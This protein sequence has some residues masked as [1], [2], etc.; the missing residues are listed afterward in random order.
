MNAVHDPR[1]TPRSRG[2]SWVTYYMVET[3]ATRRT[4]PKRSGVVS[5]HDKLT[6]F[7]HYSKGLGGMFSRDITR[8][9]RLGVDRTRIVLL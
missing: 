1:S 8:I 3:L 5:V 9:G 7:L 2:G 4:L 6:T